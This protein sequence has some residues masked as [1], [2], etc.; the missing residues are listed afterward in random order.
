MADIQ[1]FDN[2]NILKRRSLPYA[3]Y[4]GDMELTD[5]QKKRRQRLALILEDYIAI[6]FELIK[7]E[8]ESDM[9]N[10]ATVKQELTYNLYDLLADE[11]YFD[12]DSELDKY[13]TDTV[14]NAYTS[15]VENMG[16]HPMDYDYLGETP[17]WVSEDRAIFMAE[18]EANTLCN[19]AE[20]VEAK[21]KG[22]THKIWV[23]Y[24]DDRVRPTHIEVEGARIPIDLYFDVGMAHM[25]Y[26]KDVTS[27]FSTGAE[28]PEETVNCR[29]SISYI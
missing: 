25:L 6:F 12:N 1:N 11:N 13:I 18:N 10:E 27:E 23:T 22:Y 20:F 9:L 2:I 19:S 24:S 5:K 4:F 29:C 16:N 14:N 28:H 21:E 7:S 3:E 15:T 26:P 8:M 17:Y